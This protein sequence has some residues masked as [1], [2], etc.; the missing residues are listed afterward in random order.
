[1]HL[2]NTYKKSTVSVSTASTDELHGLLQLIRW[3]GSLHGDLPTTEDVRSELQRREFTDPLM[4]L[5]TSGFVGRRDLEVRLKAHLLNDDGLPCLVFGPGGVG[6]STVAANMFV[7]DWKEFSYQRAYLNFDKGK[8]A[9]ANNH[10]IIDEIVRQIALFSPERVNQYRVREFRNNLKKRMSETPKEMGF[11]SQSVSYDEHVDP[12]IIEQMANVIEGE[13]L[14]S[15]S[16]NTLILFDTFEQVQRRDISHTYR[17]YELIKNIRKRIPSVR[18]IIFGR[19]PIDEELPIVKWHLRD[20]ERP[21]AI[22]LLR[23]VTES[24]EIRRETIEE[25]IDLVGCN[26]LSIRLAGDILLREGHHP[27]RN[28]QITEKQIQGQL[29]SR[30]L[31]HIRNPDVRSI[32]HPGLVVRRITPEIIR[33][34][35][36]GPC[37]ID[38]QEPSAADRLFEALRKEATLMEESPEGDGALVHRTDVRALMLKAI[39]KTQRGKARQIQSIG[40]ALLPETCDRKVS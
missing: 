17:V 24:A 40:C 33:E 7:G 13:S 18:F 26:P 35:L 39:H 12:E 23:R 36:A 28:L 14:G 4:S 27:L 2:Q 3:F 20:I 19:A 38:I 30:I 29:Y 11:S 16:G 6:K 21:E 15:I 32:A 31:D 10:T 37:G 1:M 25:V 34:I 22:T 8:L 5:L 9:N